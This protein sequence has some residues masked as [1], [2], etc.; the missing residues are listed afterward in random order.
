VCIVVV[1]ANANA[2]ERCLLMSELLQFTQCAHAYCILLAD[3]YT[4]LKSEQWYNARVTLVL[5]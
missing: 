5:W 4:N 3:K 1:I 2:V